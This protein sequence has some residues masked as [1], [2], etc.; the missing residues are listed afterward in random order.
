MKTPNYQQ[1]QGGYLPRQ[2]SALVQLRKYAYT[3]WWS[4][5]DRLTQ[6]T[7]QTA[8]YVLHRHFGFTQQQLAESLYVSVRTVR[9]D[10]QTSYFLYEHSPLAKREADKLYDFIKNKNFYKL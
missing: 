10:I 8:V 9:N 2:K 6:A 5:T 4:T 7:R 1:I 3:H